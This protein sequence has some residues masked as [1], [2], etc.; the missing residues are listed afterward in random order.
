MKTSNYSV[1]FKSRKYFKKLQ[2]F[3]LSV[4]IN[5][6]NFIIYIIYFLQHR[7]VARS[8]PGSITA[9]MDVGVGD[10]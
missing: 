6:R 1:S 10:Q 7:R 3:S 4:E 2:K 8:T 5:V 9:R